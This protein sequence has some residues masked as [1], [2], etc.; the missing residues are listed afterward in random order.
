MGA[1]TQSAEVFA[2]PYWVADALGVAQSIA[3]PRPMDGFPGT[4]P[5]R[6]DL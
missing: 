1:A 2:L 6:L 5:I 3:A 4:S